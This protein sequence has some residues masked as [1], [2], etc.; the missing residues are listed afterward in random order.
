MRTWGCRGPRPATSL[1]ISRSGALLAIGI[2]AGGIAVVA[3]PWLARLA[4]ARQSAAFRPVV[5]VAAGAVVLSM[6]AGLVHALLRALQQFEAVGRVVFITSVISPA[7][8]FLAIRL[9]PSLMAAV[10]ANL[11]VAVVSL[12]LSIGS[13]RRALPFVPPDAGWE[14]ARLREMIAF[15]GWAAVGRCAL[16]VVLHLDRVLVAMLGSVAGLAHYA[17]AA[18]L[19]ARVNLLGGVST[20][21][22]YSRA[23]VLHASDRLQEF[24]DQHATVRRILLCAALTLTLPL[25]MLGPAFLEVWIGPDTRAYGSPILLTLAAGHAVMSVTAIDAAVIDGA[26]R[27]DLTARTM[28]AWA[29]VAAATGFV[30][31]PSLDTTAIA[32]AVGLW[33]AGV[34]FTTVLLR[35]RF[36]TPRGDAARWRTAAGVAAAAAASLIVTRAVEAQVRDVPTAIAAMGACGVAVA[37]AGVVIILRPRD[38]DAIVS[39]SASHAALARGA[40]V[41]HS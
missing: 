3:G 32:V 18:Q 11:L 26:G 23:S 19:A 17:L 16:L 7:A 35:R 25:V 14:Y 34:G 30:L 15:T 29:V 4:G 22:V 2:A 12:F 39:L 6:Q 1:K 21:M 10:G 37:A 9:E 8:T 28:V 27:P 20:A 33:L 5:A 40:A 41:S 13:A 36:L 31:H 24:G 38:R